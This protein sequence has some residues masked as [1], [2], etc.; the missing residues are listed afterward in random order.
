MKRIFTIMVL[1]VAALAFSFTTSQAQGVDCG[2]CDVNNPT[3]TLLLTP[4]VSNN[5]AEIEVRL[6][7]NHPSNSL[8]LT[9]IE[10]SMGINSTNLSALT[11]ITADATVFPNTPALN[12]PTDLVAINE[13]YTAQSRALN[14]QNYD[15]HFEYDHTAGGTN[16]PPVSI[17]G[18][19]T[20]QI[21]TISLTLTS[22]HGLTANNLGDPAFLAGYPGAC[23]A[24]DPNI[25]NQFGFMNAGLVNCYDVQ[26]L[27]TGG[28]PIDLVEFEGEIY[29]RFNK[30][31]WSTFSESN[32]GWHAVERSLDPTSSDF[33]EIGKIRAAGN[34]SEVL[35]YDL[36]DEN[37][38]EIAYYRLRTDDLDGNVHYSN[39]VVLKR[40]SFNNI[41]EVYPN[42]TVGEFEA[43]VSAIADTEYQYEIMDELGRVLHTEINSEHKGLN[44]HEFDL[45]MY[46]DGIYYLKIKTGQETFVKLITKV[47]P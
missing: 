30:L 6:R 34:S 40:G 22:G 15:M 33:V 14:S 2:T 16:N 3:F 18:N 1:S 28:L 44:T 35:S 12:P 21:M 36:N 39:I 5:S 17:A 38:P 19:S 10:F 4:S 29:D 8:D 7:N 31:G 46:G 20:V 45:S 24:P 42:P 37:P 9:T 23:I 43:K 13:Q 25:N 27:P 47:T 26:M 41:A 32:T 11:A